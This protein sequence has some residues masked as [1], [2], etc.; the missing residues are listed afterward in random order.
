[1]REAPRLN[2]PARIVRAAALG[3]ALAL[4]ATPAPA[5]GTDESEA[6]ALVETLAQEA[7]AAMR[8]PEGDAA[9]K[10]ALA[11]AFAFDIWARFLIG[12]H[13][14][15]AEE[16]ARFEALLPGY[17]ARLYARQFGQ[18]LDS[19]PRIAGTRSVR[20]DVLVE[21]RIPRE[22]AEPLPVDYRVRH[23]NGA[24]PRVIDLMVGGVSF[25]LTK[26][27]EFSAL[28]ERAGVAGLLAH[29]EARAE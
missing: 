20:R 28:V 8:A 21:A 17:L 27:A 7:H 4:L 3:L 14:L 5:A 25:L 22:G 1:M 26:R 19:R 2:T 29:M 13:G 24:G 11:R 16:R 15:S 23:V 12:Q 18:G 10:A 9:L 6:R